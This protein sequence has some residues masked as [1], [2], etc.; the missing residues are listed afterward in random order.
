MSHFTIG[1]PNSGNDILFELF[2]DFFLLLF[3]AEIKLNAKLRE[4]LVLAVLSEL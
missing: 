2:H 4:E 1:K 3:E